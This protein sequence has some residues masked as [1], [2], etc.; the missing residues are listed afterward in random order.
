[1]GRDFALYGHERRRGPGP[2]SVSS[3]TGPG[4][5]IASAYAW[6]G[7][8]AYNAAKIGSNAVKL[9]RSSDNATQDFVLQSNGG[10]DD[11]A[12]TSF[13]G[14]GN[15]F[16]DT[17]YDQ[18]GSYHLTQSVAGQQ[19]QFVQSVIGSLP[20]LR[21]VKASSQVLQFTGTVAAQSQPI[22]LA[23]VAN[24]N[25]SGAGSDDTLFGQFTIN[26]VSYHSAGTARWNA[27]GGVNATQSA[28]NDAFHA[29][30]IL[31]N[32]TSSLVYVDAS[33][34]STASAGTNGIVNGTIALGAAVD[35]VFHW[36]GDF[37]EI[38]IWPIGF[39]GTQATNINT[40]QHTYWGF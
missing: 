11:A 3:Y 13:K 17:L 1:M 4:D 10:L 26:S 39:N 18:V 38:G 24:N 7:L 8:R 32:D 40:N 28:S 37:T 35:G 15:V 36:G 34:G 9:R 16:V 14:G 19:P 12:I 5:V 21:F 33:A 22:S 31:A 2:A 29:V 27:G 23:L 25:S 30:Q 20:A 6:W